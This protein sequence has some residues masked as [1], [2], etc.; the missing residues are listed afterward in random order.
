MCLS[1]C[2]LGETRA[3]WME[4]KYGIGWRID[5]DNQALLTGYDAET[6]VQDVLEVPGVSYV[7]FN[8]SDPAYGDNYLAPHSVLDAINSGLNPDT[9]LADPDYIDNPAGLPTPDGGRDLFGELATLFQANGIKVIAYMATQGPTMLKHGLGNNVYDSVLD[10]DTGVYTSVSYT[11]WETFVKNAYGLSDTPSYDDYT[12]AYAEYIVAEYAERYG[13]LIDGYWFDNGTMDAEALEE[14]ITMYN[15]DVVATYNADSDLSDY[16]DGHPTP[17]AQARASNDINYYKLIHPIENSDDG[18]ISDGVS[19]T[20]LG[21][22]FMMLQWR[23]NSDGLVWLNEEGGTYSNSK[24]IDDNG[25]VGDQLTAKG[26]D[27]MERTLNAGGAWTWNLDVGDTLNGDVNATTGEVYST[28]RPDAKALLQTIIAIKDQS[29]T[30]PQ[31][32][33]RS[34]LLSDGAYNTAYSAS[35]AGYATDVD[36]DTVRYELLD[37]PSWVSLASDGTLTGTPSS[38]GDIGMNRLKVLAYDGRG[39]VDKAEVE[40][41]IA[42]NG[43]VA[44]KSIFFTDVS[45]TDVGQVNGVDVA[46][47]EVTI[48]HDDSGDDLIISLSV[49]NQ[50]LDTIG[51]ND[52]SLSWDIR[53]EAFADS[54]FTMD[55]E[56]SS[57]TLGTPDQDVTGGYLDIGTGPTGLIGAG[58]SVRIT[59]ENVQ[60]TLA[61]SSSIEFTAFTGHWGVPASGYIFGEGSGLLSILPTANGEITYP[62]Q[63]ELI[64]TSAAVGR[65][66]YLNGYFS[67]IS[68]SA[69]YFRTAYVEQ[70][71]NAQSVYSTSLS[72]LGALATDDDGNSI[73]YSI[74]SGPAW[75]TMDSAGN[76]SGT[77]S[78]ADTGYTEVIV[79]AEDTLGGVDTLIL[80]V[81]V[82]SEN[83]PT[84]DDL[85]SSTEVGEGVLL[86]LSGYDADGDSLTYEITKYPTLGTLSGEL[87][88]ILY[89]PYGVG[90]DTIEYIV[91][92]GVQQSNV[93]TV[94]VESTA[95]TLTPGTVIGID[96]GIKSNGLVPGW[97]TLTAPGDQL[98]AG[99][100]TDLNGNLV[101]GVSF[102]TNVP[103]T[104]STGN[105]F[106][107]AGYTLIPNDVQVDRWREQGTGQFE[108]TFSGLD[109]S[110]TYDLVI[111]CEFYGNSIRN[112]QYDTGWIV[113]GESLGTEVDDPT[114]S[115]VIFTNLATDGAG[116]IEISTYD[117]EGNIESAVSALYLRVFSAEYAA[118][119]SDYTSV[120]DRAFDADADSDGY[121]NA[122]EYLFNT[123]P[124]VYNRRAIVNNCH[125]DRG[126]RRFRLNR[127][128]NSPLDTRQ[129]LQY[130]EDMTN[131]TTVD[132]TSS[133]TGVT[134]AEPDLLGMESVTVSVDDIDLSENTFFWRVVLEQE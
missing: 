8:L 69:P 67:V 83:A 80:E 74:I 101:P 127:N 72:E 71:V 6:M 19:S 93:A 45:P 18:Y 47:P 95:A 37:G 22:V 38:T 87:P 36:G 65:V 130:S 35:I 12:K 25:Q 126:S 23:W 89:T 103:E 96:F 4:G 124:T 92:D 3:N 11:N 40:I 10:A 100:T 43:A 104:T 129:V 46:L 97:N 98:A 84:A 90:T 78:T 41:Y 108:F 50:S 5:A 27:W 64:I 85:A 31:F 60:S 109:D 17:V 111:G 20:A 32:G 120:R 26:A 91:T 75:L 54:T 68:N 122:I 13:T 82:P 134:V 66:R 58:D 14:V 62:D 61:P 53:V 107:N 110:K 77:P 49:T 16:A 123:D 48:T 21:H 29:S 24:D 30:P 73:S 131:W 44:S 15:P 63:E 117:Y 118:Y 114:G 1:V 56:N 9:G 88:D 99:V 59:V 115:Y 28:L 116:N 105:A 94:T 128:A 2:L 70:T 86:S 57:V 112:T 133:G 125:L 81:S 7:L 55:G 102:V 106:Y 76:L 39:E 33:A 132:I 42:A 79:Q 121:S 113:N 52:D 51:E 119:I 34:Y